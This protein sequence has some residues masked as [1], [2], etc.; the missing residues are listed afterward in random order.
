MCTRPARGREREKD[1]FS[2]HSFFLFFFFTFRCVPPHLFLLSDENFWGGR[3]TLTRNVQPRLSRWICNLI[4]WRLTSLISRILCAVCCPCIVN[5]DELPQTGS[6]SN[7]ALPTIPNSSPNINQVCRAAAPWICQ[8]RARCPLFWVSNIRPPPI[9]H[10]P[11]AAAVY[12]L[13]NW[14]LN[15]P[16]HLIDA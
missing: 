8:N 16:M 11:S 9:I 10:S 5:Y 15:T 13:W 2:W 1:G 12:T 7:L 14:H 3:S 6:Q 4:T